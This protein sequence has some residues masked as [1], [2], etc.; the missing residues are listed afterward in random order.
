[1]KRMTPLLAVCCA[2]GFLQAC[3]TG[4]ASNPANSSTQTAA[5]GS[6]SWNEKAAAAYLD[7]RQQWWMEW[8]GAQRGS[9]FCLSCHTTLPYMLARPQLDSM[10]G[11]SKPSADEQKLVAD[12]TE[13]VRDWST[14]RPYYSDSKERPHLAQD[15]RGTESVL[16]AFVLVSRDSATGELSDDARLALDHMWNEQV[17][18]GAQ[19]GAWRWQQFG[20][21]PWESQNSIYYGAILA[22]ATVGMTPREYQSSPSVQSRVTLLLEY[23]DK[24]Y[25]DQCLLN[26][27]ELLWAAG[28]F[29]GLIGPSRQSEIIRQVFATQHADG[30]WNTSSLVVPDGW[31][32]ARFMAV[33]DRRRDG[34]RQDD[35][36]DGLATGMI[37]S[38]L[39]Q[40]GVS[41]E[42]PQM[43][44]AVDWLCR[45]QN[46]SGSWTASSLNERRDPNSYI[47]EF[48]SDAATGYAVLALTQARTRSK[49]QGGY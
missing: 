36:S 37:V 22:A 2:A 10:L 47:G 42:T 7:S 39:L 46:A 27:I 23:L 34:S 32:R 12:V 24:G 26:R 1:M 28:R 11:Q 3:S 45:H 40:S 43:R 41:V 4:S 35:Q 17:Q 14:D 29:H 5:F 33:F 16:N 38:A 13:R 19:K 15:A 18:T 9:T 20:L 49:V 44:R 25:A 48:M 30:G 21:E 8:K 31:N 6:A